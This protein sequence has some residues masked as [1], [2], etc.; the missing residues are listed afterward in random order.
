MIETYRMCTRCVMDTTDP[1][2]EFDMNGVCNHCKRYD[3]RV[4]KNVF[5]GEVGK[6][7]LN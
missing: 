6:K 4:S 2:I 7:K 5:V 1:D 3:Y